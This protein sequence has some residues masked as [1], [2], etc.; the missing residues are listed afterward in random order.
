MLSALNSANVRRKTPNHALLGSLA[1]LWANLDRS[2]VRV[3][4]TD[5]YPLTFGA[6][7]PLRAD[8]AEE[9]GWTHGSPASPLPSLS[10]RA[11]LAQPGKAPVR[12]GKPGQT[13]PP[14]GCG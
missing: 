11:L 5:L 1:G 12:A 4:M 6:T 2:S 14:P 7:L 9:R 3:A 13:F 10:P 8:V